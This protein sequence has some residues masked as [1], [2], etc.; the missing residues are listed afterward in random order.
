MLCSDVLVSDSFCN[1]GIY[2]EDIMRLGIATIQRN[3]GSWL[4]EWFAFHYLVGFTKFYFYAHKCEDDTMSKLLRLSQSFDI[5]SFQ[6][7]ESLD[8]PQLQAYQHAYDNFGHEVDWMAFIDGDEFLFPTKTY[9]MKESLEKFHYE[10]LSALGIYWVCFG[11]SGHKTEPLGL[12]VDNFKMRARFDFD[13]NKHIKSIVLGRQK[14][15]VSSNAHYFNTIYGTFDEQLRPVTGGNMREYEP[16]YDVFRINHYA[17]QSY[18]YFKKTKQTSGMPDV[19]GCGTI[20]S[21]SWWET[22]DRNDVLDDSMEKYSSDLRRIVKQ[23]G[24]NLN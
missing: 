9:S 12:I 24:D 21:D 6:I 23:L 15:Q 10:R 8:R 17:C 4:A 14:I 2:R 22:Y 20:R 3:R 5:K 13:P 7:S 1:K 19:A 16:S 11:S 18:E